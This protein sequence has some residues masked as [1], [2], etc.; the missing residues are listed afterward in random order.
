[1]GTGEVNGSLKNFISI[2]HNLRFNDRD[3]IPVFNLDDS[4][5]FRQNI[6][7]LVYTNYDK[8]VDTFFLIGGLLVTWSLL[9]ALEK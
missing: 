2:F 7:Y 3:M 5:G 1:M 8:P 4:A 6:L 9:D